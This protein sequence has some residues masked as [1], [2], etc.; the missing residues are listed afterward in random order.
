MISAAI[1]DPSALRRAFSHH[2]T[3]VAA[4]AATVD[5]DDQVLVASS[6]MTGISVDPPLV[7]VAI[8]KSSTTW[9]VLRRASRIGV[10]LLGQDQASLCR[11]LAS[12]EK[13]ARWHGVM[14]DYTSAKALR[15]HG[16]SAWLECAAFAEHEAGDHVIVL[17]EVKDF[18]VSHSI[19]PLIFHCSRFREL[20][21]EVV[22]V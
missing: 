2:P 7:S 19:D 4:L 5:G 14:R 18:A 3:G 12:K 16:A 1:R 13:Q 10:S 11:Q 17:L 22:S 9:S 6:F 15:I 8:Q 20:V 21:P